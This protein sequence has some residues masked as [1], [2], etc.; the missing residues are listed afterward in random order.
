MQTREENVGV[1]LPHAV[2]IRLRRG[3][4]RVFH[5]VVDDAEIGG[6]T[7]QTAAH[8]DGAIKAPVTDGLEDVDVAQI[9]ALCVGRY[10][11]RIEKRAGEHLFVFKA[12]NRSLYG[13]RKTLCKACRIRRAHDF[14]LRIVAQSPRRE[15]ARYDLRFS[16][17]RADKHHKAAGR[18]SSEQEILAFLGDERVKPLSR[19]V[20]V[21]VVEE[22]GERLHSLS[23]QDF[24]LEFV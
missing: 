15:L 14:Q 12:V 20:R 1:P 2:A 22:M 4:D 24:A 9:A 18:E 10:V 7:R 21:G 17:L 11:R 19:V 5:G 3:F 6:R 23:P 8:T 13:T 16:M